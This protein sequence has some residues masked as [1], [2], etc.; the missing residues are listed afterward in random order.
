MS[1]RYLRITGVLVRDPRQVASTLSGRVTARNGEQA[2]GTVAKVQS[3]VFTVKVGQ[4]YFDVTASNRCASI[5]RGLRAGDVVEIESTDFYVDTYES[6]RTG[7]T[8][9]VIKL[10]AE[11]VRVVPK[12]GTVVPKMVT[13]GSAA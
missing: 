7:E 13:E 9:G 1:D 10:T 11:T 8:M 5:C 2:Y 4:G 3:I 6:K 12:V